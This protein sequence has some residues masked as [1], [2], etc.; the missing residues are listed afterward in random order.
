MVPVTLAD[1]PDEISDLLGEAYLLDPFN[2]PQL[3]LVSDPQ[4]P[5]PAEVVAA[6]QTLIWNAQPGV[7]L[8]QQTVAEEAGLV[9]AFGPVAVPSKL[10]VTYWRDFGDNGQEHPP[11]APLY[12]DWS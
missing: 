11:W 7:P 12:L 9:S 4:H 2:A 1:V 3:A 8:E 10:A 5:Q 6:Q